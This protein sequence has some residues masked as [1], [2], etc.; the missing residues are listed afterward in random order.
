MT[1]AVTSPAFHDPRPRCRIRRCSTLADWGSSYCPRHRVLVDKLGEFGAVRY[2]V[3]KPICADCLEPFDEEEDLDHGI[4]CDWC[5]KNLCVSC[6]NEHACEEMP[7]TFFCAACDEW[8]YPSL[9]RD[10]GEQLCRK[11]NVMTCDLHAH[12]C[13]ARATA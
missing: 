7:R 5:R 4:H 13:E 1:T 9:S 2:E 6:A 10:D 3:G 8:I 12:V 11:C